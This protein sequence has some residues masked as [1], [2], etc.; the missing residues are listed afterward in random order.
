MKDIKKFLVYYNEVEGVIGIREHNFDWEEG[1]TIRTNG[2]PTV[3]FGIFKGTDKNM[4]LASQMMKTLVKY[5][6]KQRFVRVMDEDFEQTGDLLEDTLQVVEHSHCKL[7]NTGGWKS[8]DAQLD[9]VD[10]VMAKMD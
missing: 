7:V 1:E 2:I 6:P 8:F 3:I 4:S 9:F 5:Q 10:A